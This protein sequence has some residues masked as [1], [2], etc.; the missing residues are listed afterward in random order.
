LL[1]SGA[2]ALLRQLITLH[3]GQDDAWPF[4]EQA[5]RLVDKLGERETE[6][7]AYPQIEL[8]WYHPILLFAYDCPRLQGIADCT[9]TTYACACE[10]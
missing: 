6:S 7:S 10:G 2:G 4:Y 1:W 8:R 3:G 9:L 5:Y